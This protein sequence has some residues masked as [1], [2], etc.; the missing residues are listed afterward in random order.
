M[1]ELIAGVEFGVVTSGG[2]ATFSRGSS[3]SAGLRQR[4]ALAWDLPRVRR[5]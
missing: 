5:A 2:F 3:A 4:K 1:F